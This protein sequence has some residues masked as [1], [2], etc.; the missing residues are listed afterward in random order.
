MIKNIII[1]LLVIVIIVAG[2]FFW[3]FN[4]KKEQKLNNED[5]KEITT[6]NK[7]KNKNTDNKINLKTGDNIKNGN[8]INLIGQIKLSEDKK[9]NQNINSENLGLKNN[10]SDISMKNIDISKVELETGEIWI[11]EAGSCDLIKM[12][13]ISQNSDYK[14]VELTTKSGKKF[15]TIFAKND[16]GELM[17]KNNINYTANT[18]KGIQNITSLS[19][20]HA[21]TKDKNGVYHI[22][23]SVIRLYGYNQDTLLCT[24][25][26]KKQN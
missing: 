6:D 11:K 3:N 16:D 21:I 26:F 18:Y 19:M 2:A 23:P 5:E 1:S 15:K 14:E 7:N 22:I 25:D 24:N 10:I 8:D 17:A 13:I 12:R 9:E 4:L 20:G